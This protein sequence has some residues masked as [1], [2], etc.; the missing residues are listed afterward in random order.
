MSNSKVKKWGNSLAIRL[1]KEV[2]DKLGVIDGMHIRID[3]HESKKEVTLRPQQK[4][5]PSLEELVKKITPS[6]LH[7]ETDWGAPRGN[8][9]W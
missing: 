8:E 1:P 9:F 3:I 7:P 6:N 5:V 4:V 2:V